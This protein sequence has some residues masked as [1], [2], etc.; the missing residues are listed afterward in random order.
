MVQQP[1]SYKFL[2]IRSTRDYIT[3]SHGSATMF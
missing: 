2:W 3:H 1:V